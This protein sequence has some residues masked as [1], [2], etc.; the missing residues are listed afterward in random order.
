MSKLDPTMV[1]WCDD[2]NFLVVIF[3]SH[4]DDFIWSGGAQS[5]CIINKNRA[6]FKVGRE[7]SKAF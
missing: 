7:D 3:A 2:T 6:D 4:V 5:Q 1:Y